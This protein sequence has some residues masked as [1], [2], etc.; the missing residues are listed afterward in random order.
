[1]CSRTNLQFPGL[2]ATRDYKANELVTLYLGKVLSKE[3]RDQLLDA[4][5]VRDDG[6]FI[7][8]GKSHLNDPRGYGRWIN[9]SESPN[10]RWELFWST[11]EACQYRGI[12]AKRD[13]AKGEE[14]TIDYGNYNF[15]YIMLT[16][17][18]QHIIP[19]R[20]YWRKF[21]GQSKHQNKAGRKRKTKRIINKDKTALNNV[22]ETRI[23]R[24]RKNISYKDM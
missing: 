16:F 14:F 4:T 17:L 11:K 9:H 6:T 23:L 18:I 7:I 1:M 13:I 12:K 2:F 24:Q 22:Q 5:Y 21:G 19:G 8:D 3:Y 20:G 15:I 10:C